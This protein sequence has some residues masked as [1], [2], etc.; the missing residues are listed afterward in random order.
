MLC[1]RCM[2]E[3][4]RTNECIKCGVIVDKF[5]ETQKG[6]LDDM[7]HKYND[8]KIK[9][10]MEPYQVEQKT[11]RVSGPYKVLLLLFF[12]FILGNT[13]FVFI[14]NSLSK[15]ATEKAILAAF[16]SDLKTELQH[17]VIASTISNICYENLID[18]VPD[19]ITVDFVLDEDPTR[20]GALHYTL[21]VTVPYKI[22]YF[23]RKLDS[24]MDFIVVDSVPENTMKANRLRNIFEL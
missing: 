4:E 6:P 15:D 13:A 22:A 12:I 3:Q 9:I 8:D 20:D 1:P 16:N 2:Y 18:V 5:L 19:K 21:Y 14:N 23:G 10:H 24:H 17:S 7:P 11:K